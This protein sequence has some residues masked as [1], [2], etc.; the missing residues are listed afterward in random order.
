MTQPAG[1]GPVPPKQ[2]H[3]WPAGGS[4]AYGELYRSAVDSAPDDPRQRGARGAAAP[5]TDCQGSPRWGPAAIAAAGIPLGLLWWLL[6]PGGMN[7]LTGDPSLASGTNAEG[8]LPRD[9]VLAGL[10]LFAGCLTGVLL[11]GKH[12]GAPSPS[13]VVLAVIAGAVGAVIA[14]RVGILAAQFWGA[15]EDTSPNA[16]IA[17]SLRAYAVL[18]I[19]PAAVAV[20]VFVVNL[21]SLL[22]K[23]PRHDA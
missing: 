12:A 15:A 9:L 3:P 11:T 19:W 1:N 6:A 2:H 8:W 10:F 7:L 4:P 21:V 5:T 20:A 16:S 13:A 17:F 18:A 23:A 22:G 14:W